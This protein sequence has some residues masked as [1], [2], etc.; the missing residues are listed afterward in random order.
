M[1]RQGLA[2]SL[3]ATGVLFSCAHAA[4][5]QPKQYG[6]Y[7]RYVLALVANRFLPEPAC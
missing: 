7:D 4:P 6:D 5:L 1:F 2:V 3:C